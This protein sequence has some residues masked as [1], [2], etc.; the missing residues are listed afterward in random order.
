MTTA[1]D[2]VPRLGGDALAG[3]CRGLAA[4]VI[5]LDRVGAGV[6]AACAL[7]V[8]SPHVEVGP[9]LTRL[10]ADSA[11]ASESTVAGLGELDLGGGRPDEAVHSSRT[12]TRAPAAPAL[13][14]FATASTRTPMEP[15]LPSSDSRPP[16]PAAHPT[17]ATS[18]P[19]TSRTATTRPLPVAT[20][21]SPSV[22]RA[23]EI[24]RVGVDRTVVI[25]SPGSRTSVPDRSAAGG[26]I[27]QAGGHADGGTSPAHTDDS[28]SVRMVLRPGPSAPIPLL[29]AY[30]GL[31]DPLQPAPGSAQPSGADIATGPVQARRTPA[32]RSA[33][34][35]P[36][37]AARSL[38][39]LAPDAGTAHKP[40]GIRRG[41]DALGRGG[42]RGRDD[43]APAQ[44][45]PTGMRRIWSEGPDEPRHVGS[46]G[47]DVPRRAG[48]GSDERLEEDEPLWSGG[49]MHAAGMDDDAVER[50]VERVLRD[51]A[52]RHGIEV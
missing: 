13:D 32:G 34:A 50:V 41:R 39:Q 24:R 46:A 4:A 16:R 35:P 37:P 12:S 40:S 5:R 27:V 19:A 7:G 9:L 11:V 26:G 17:L 3:W 18:R 49:L 14:H 44:G 23:L 30:A 8:E 45:W 15:K 20:A 31:R 1:T 10:R 38:G 36:D 51:T 25:S 42:R 28:A 22:R 29:A 2:A 48:H 33:A 43:D 52:R 21:P 47:I 6:R